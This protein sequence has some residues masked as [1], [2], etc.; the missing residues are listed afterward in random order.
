MSFGA[1]IE[2]LAS[3]LIT[4]G[5]YALVALGFSIVYHASP[6]LWNPAESGWNPRSTMAS[7]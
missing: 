2:L 4:G 3:G 5:I 1:W 7:P 6:S